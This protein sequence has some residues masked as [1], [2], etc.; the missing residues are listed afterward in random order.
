M[1]PEGLQSE[2]HELP[3]G[4]EGQAGQ[5]KEEDDG[6][7]DP[8]HHGGVRGKVGIEQPEVFG[9]FIRRERDTPEG[10]SDTNHGEEAQRP[11]PEAGLG[12]GSQRPHAQAQ[13]RPDED[14]VREVGDHSD[15]DGKPPDERQFLE[16]DHEGGGQQFDGG[17]TEFG[18]ACLG[19]GQAV[20]AKKGAGPGGGGPKL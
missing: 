19:H 5:R 15:F 16:E 7:A 18:G 3:Q 11:Q 6:K 1:R 4:D 10:P 9:G 17:A 20:S 12:R 2:S 14:Q 8:L 13:K